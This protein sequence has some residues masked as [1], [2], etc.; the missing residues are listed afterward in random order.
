MIM[1]LTLKMKGGLRLRCTPLDPAAAPHPS[2]ATGEPAGGQQGNRAA[3]S[4]TAAGGAQ[5]GQ[6][7]PGQASV[8]KVSGV[9]A[10]GQA[11]LGK[12]GAVLAGAGAALASSVRSWTRGSVGFGEEGDEEW[13]EAEEDLQVS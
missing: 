2:S 3:A 12:A 13:E 7:G 8:G 6:Q 1:S 5:E 4:Q 10:A 9:S 11:V